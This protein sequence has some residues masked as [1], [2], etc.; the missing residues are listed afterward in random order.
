MVRADQADQAEFSCFRF[1][2]D[3]AFLAPRSH[4]I[5]LIT[6][7][8]QAKHVHYIVHKHPLEGCLGKTHNT[9]THFKKHS[10][11]CKQRRRC[12]REGKDTKVHEGGAFGIAKLALELARSVDPVG[13][14]GVESSK[15][16]V[17]VHRDPPSATLVPY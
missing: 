13:Y 17:Q 6:A 14:Q 8:L 5:A 10:S 1:S 16:V 7:R 12:K 2:G 11:A 4:P 3:L 9:K 15:S